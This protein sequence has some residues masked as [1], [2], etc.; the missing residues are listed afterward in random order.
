MNCVLIIDIK[1]LKY[2]VLF[3]NLN[4]FVMLMLRNLTTYKFNI[5]YKLSRISGHYV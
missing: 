5:K 3:I 4:Q 1:Y 2:V